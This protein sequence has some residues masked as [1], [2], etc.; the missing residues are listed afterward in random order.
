MKVNQEVD[1]LV[2]MGVDPMTTLVLPRLLAAMLVMPVL[3]VLL[4]IAGL[5]GMSVVL[6]G[7]GIPLVAIGNQIAYWVRP[8]DFY[9]GLAKAVVFGAVVAAIGCRE[10]LAAG[11]GPRAVGM[12]ATAA[13]VGGIVS[14]IGLDGLFAVLFYRLGL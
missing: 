6:V 10:G 11:N 14:T 13:V 9:G 1:A 7:S 3:T 8:Q 12:A 2:T 5:I 4:E